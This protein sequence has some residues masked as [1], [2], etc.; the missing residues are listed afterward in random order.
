M[1]KNTDSGFQ[2]GKIDN[3]IDVETLPCK[4]LNH[5]LKYRLKINNSIDVETLPCKVLNHDLKYRL[6]MAR[7]YCMKMKRKP[8]KIYPCNRRNP[9]VIRVPVFLRA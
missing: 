1:I 6:R 4:V 8:Y 9:S 5:D 3:S 2:D 7:F